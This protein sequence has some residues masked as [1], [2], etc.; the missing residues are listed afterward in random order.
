MAMRKAHWDG[1]ANNLQKQGPTDVL[2]TQRK[3]TPLTTVGAGIVTPDAVLSGLVLRTGPVGGF[4]DTFPSALQ[5]INAI[6]EFSDN[7]SFEFSYI[8]GVAQAMTFA[9]GA[10]TDAT[11]GTVNVAASLIR[12]YLVTLLA[13]GVGGVLPA[14]TVN[15]SPI[16]TVSD[17]R[18]LDPVV[19]GAKFRVGQSVTGTGIGAAAVVRAINYTTGQITLSVN[20]TADGSN[21]AVTFA[22]RVEYRGLWSATA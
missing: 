5:L 1:G 3:T 18:L 8:N 10:A 19:G 17:L 4:T 7:D 21:I 9:V 12:Q 20:S 14:T 6:P 16:I 15:G 11:A 22:P 2:M 13:G